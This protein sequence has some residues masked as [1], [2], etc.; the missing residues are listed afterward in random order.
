[1][2]HYRRAIQPGGTFFF[3]VVTYR[4]RPWLL[5]DDARAALREAIGRTRER[6]PFN[7]DAWVLMPDHLHCVWTLPPGD[8]DFATRWGLIKRRVSMALGDALHVPDWMNAS[9]TKHRESTLWQRRYFEHTIRDEADF[10]RCVDYLHHNPVKHG[11]VSRVVDWEWS[12]FHRYV[13]EGIY[14]PDWAGTDWPDT[15]GET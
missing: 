14:A 15:I 13:T 5:R 7:I 10:A 9:K 8:A 11:L 3:T 4:R 1:M 2:S 6:H 12:S